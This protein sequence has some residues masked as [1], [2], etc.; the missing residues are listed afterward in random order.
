M[1]LHVYLEVTSCCAGVV[2]L[3]AT[4]RLPSRACQHVCLEHVALQVLSLSAT[5]VTLV[6][7]E[8]LLSRMCQHVCL[9]VV[10]S[11]AGKLALFAIEIL[12]S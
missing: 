12:F 6:T 10:R 2:A 3:F 8:R 9:E 4:E 7:P 11:C 1:D 5:I